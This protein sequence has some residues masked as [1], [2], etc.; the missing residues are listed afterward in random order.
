MVFQTIAWSCKVRCNYLV[1]TWPEGVKSFRRKCRRLIL[2]AFQWLPSEKSNIT[3]FSKAILRMCYQDPGC[4]FLSFPLPSYNKAHDQEK[5]KNGFPPPDFFFFFFLI[6]HLYVAV[7]HISCLLYGY[8]SL[9]SSL[10]S[11][12]PIFTLTRKTLRSGCLWCSILC[13]SSPNLLPSW[14]DFTPKLS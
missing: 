9:Y 14:G 5:T 11:Q 7:T 6:G 13:R 1:S 2:T 10:T 3:F 12:A 4:L 8:L